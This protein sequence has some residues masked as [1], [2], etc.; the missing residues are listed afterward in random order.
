MKAMTCNQ[1]GG[2]CEMHFH[3]ETFEEMVE[4]AKQHGMEMA[5]KGDEAHIEVMKKMKDMMENNPEEVEKWTEEKKKEFEALSN[6][7]AH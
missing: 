2:A 6:H 5:E 3:A 4:Q 7:P 1:L